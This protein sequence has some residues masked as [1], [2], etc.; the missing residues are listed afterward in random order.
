MSFI[1][2]QA[3]GDVTLSSDIEKAEAALCYMKST[4]LSHDSQTHMLSLELA[5]C[6][7]IS[8]LRDDSAKTNKP[9]AEVK[10]HRV[11]PRRP[12]PQNES[13]KVSESVLLPLM[14]YYGYSNE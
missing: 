9:T 11:I 6:N 3:I 2:T 4:T 1:F 7:L 12:L 8:R 10:G 13:T 5:L 14:C